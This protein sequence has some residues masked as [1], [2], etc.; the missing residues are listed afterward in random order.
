MPELN[1]LVTRAE[2]GSHCSNTRPRP[3]GQ[4]AKYVM[5]LALT[6]ETAGLRH[7]E[8]LACEEHF[9]QTRHTDPASIVQVTFYDGP[10]GN[11]QQ[12]HDEAFRPIKDAREARDEMVHKFDPDGRPL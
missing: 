10:D 12:G 1:N 3:C 5:R 11:W 8:V 9:Q 4:P 6:V 2:L 7:I